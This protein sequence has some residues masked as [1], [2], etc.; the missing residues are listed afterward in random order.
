[1]YVTFGRRKYDPSTD[2]ERRPSCECREGHRAQEREEPQKEQDDG[3]A[4][5][6]T[7]IST[8]TWAF[9]VQ[10]STLICVIQHYSSSFCNVYSGI[11]C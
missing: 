5:L 3:L 8:A 9:Y 2:A 6:F 10:L 4:D 7:T 11:L 1:M